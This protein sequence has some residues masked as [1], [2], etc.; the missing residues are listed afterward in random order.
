MGLWGVL[1]EIFKVVAPH[2]APHVAQAVKER[3]AAGLAEQRANAVAQ[4]IAHE[5]TTLEERIAAAELKAAASEAR[6]AD[7][8][9][10]LSL[11]QTQMAGRWA[12]MRIWALA[13]L[14]W[15]AV[16]TAVLVY[17]L[18]ARR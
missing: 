14:A 9:E 5:F 6:A 7:A 4:E 3:R 17:L 16:I 13:L 11:L 1:W 18:A 8:E 10:K 15:N 2:T 12:T